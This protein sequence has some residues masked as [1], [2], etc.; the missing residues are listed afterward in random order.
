MKSN[1]D[2]FLSLVP[3]TKKNRMIALRRRRDQGLL[4]GDRGLLFLH[5]LEQVGVDPD[6][7]RVAMPELF[8]EFAQRCRGCAEKGTC[9]Q[10]AASDSF[11]ERVVAYCPNTPK[12]DDL[13]LKK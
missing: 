8:G 11:N 9:S 12:I 13:I 3:F 2:R 6:Y 5:R 10:D 1:L 4:P 7:V